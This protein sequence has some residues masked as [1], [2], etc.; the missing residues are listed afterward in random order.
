MTRIKLLSAWTTDLTSGT[1][2]TIQVA[3]MQYTKT[4]P[5]KRNDELELMLD[6]LKGQ[7]GKM[8]DINLSGFAKHEV[9][10]AKSYDG[11]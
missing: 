8:I 1:K 9:P 10:Y 3:T 5:S 6:N 2:L 11:Y 7:V 4:Y